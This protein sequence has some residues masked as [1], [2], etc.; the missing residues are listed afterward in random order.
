MVGIKKEIL[1]FCR[2]HPDED[3]CRRLTAWLE[4]HGQAGQ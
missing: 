1:Q 3:F 2:E 4:A